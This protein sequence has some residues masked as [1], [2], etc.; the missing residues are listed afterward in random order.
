MNPLTTKGQIIGAAVQGIGG[1]LYEELMYEED[2]QPI[3]TTFM[4][5]L[6]PGA[7]EMPNVDYFI[8][9]DAKS[10]DNSFGAKGLGEV[11]LIAAGAAIAAAIDD[12]L[13]DDIHTD[14]LPVKPEQIF[15]RCQGTNKAGSQL[16]Q[17]DSRTDS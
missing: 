7:Y 15:N 10:P 13:S 16:V 5:Y 8:T 3:T 6:L 12:A 9:E 1:A 11:G 2:G 4:D 14:R 17:S